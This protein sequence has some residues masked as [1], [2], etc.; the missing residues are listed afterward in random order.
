MAQQ[1][2]TAGDWV[3][4]HRGKWSKLIDHYPGADP[5]NEGDTAGLD[6]PACLPLFLS[7]SFYL[8]LHSPYKR[9]E[10]SIPAPPAPPLGKDHY[11]SGFVTERR[12]ERAQSLLKY[13]WICAAIWNHVFV[14]TGGLCLLSGQCWV[15]ED[16]IPA[17]P[18]TRGR[19]FF[20]EGHSSMT[21]TP[22]VKLYL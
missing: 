12:Q 1:S 13:G 19:K 21:K 6:L 18:R 2:E 22:S 10:A 7:L 14:W 20:T 3:L 9:R 16:V 17:G 8:S 4:P 11:N 5:G 15:P